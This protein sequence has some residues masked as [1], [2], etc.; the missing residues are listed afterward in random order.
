[1]SAD[2][3]KVIPSYE[4]VDADTGMRPGDT[5]ICEDVRGEC[6]RCDIVESHVAC[7]HCCCKVTFLSQEHKHSAMKTSFFPSSWKKLMLGP[8]ILGEIRD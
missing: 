7:G 3:T 6:D 4:D 5:T 1:M 8:N 2:A